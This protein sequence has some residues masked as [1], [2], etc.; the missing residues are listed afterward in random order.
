MF[1]L[2]F[3]HWGIKGNELKYGFVAFSGIALISGIACGIMTADYAVCYSP[4]CIIILAY[5]LV[6]VFTQK[7]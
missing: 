7:K 6:S 4:L 3:K 1:A 5:I 2:K